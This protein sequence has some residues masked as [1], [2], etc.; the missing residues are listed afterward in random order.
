MHSLCIKK[1]FCIL[2]L[3]SKNNIKIC[4]KKLIFIFLLEKINIKRRI[5]N[6]SAKYS[7]IG[8]LVKQ[9]ESKN[10]NHLGVPASWT[11]FSQV[12]RIR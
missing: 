6:F 12:K 5:R 7:D 8:K 1:F 2:L 4:L 10:K 11:C 9:R 3:N